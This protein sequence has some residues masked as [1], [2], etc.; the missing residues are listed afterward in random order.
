MRGRRLPRWI[1]EPKRLTRLQ[2]WGWCLLALAAVAAVG[3]L[4]C[5]IRRELSL[6]IFYLLPILPAGWF[7]GRRPALI[8]SAASAAVWILADA[9]TS[10]FPFQFAFSLWNGLARLVFF[11]VSAFLVVRLRQALTAETELARTD[12]LTGAANSRAF[13]ELAE[14]ELER[15]RRYKR[16]LTIAYID[17]D[18]FKAVNDRFGHQTGD[19]LLKAVAAVLRNRTRSVDAVARLAGDEFALLLPETGPEAAQVAVGRLQ[20]ALLTGMEEQKWPVTFSLGVVTYLSP[21]DNVQAMI[22]M[23][24]SRM[25]FAKRSGKNQIRWEVFGAPPMPTRR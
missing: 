2:I 19:L 5:H 20:K 9:L 23:A 12:F 16:P 3:W 17:L 4:D 22:Q 1:E 6:A 21:P 7:L 11:L 15:L 18:N 10:P 8:V 14:H 13:Y 24:D 25:Y